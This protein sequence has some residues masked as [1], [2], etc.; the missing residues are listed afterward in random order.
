[1]LHRI[2]VPIL[3]LTTI[4]ACSEHPTPPPTAP[5]APADAPPPARE[6]L[7]ARLAVALADPVL[8]ADLATRFDASH[9]PEGKLQFQALARTGDRLLLA[10]LAAAG[11]GSMATLL[12]DLDAARGLELYLPVPAQRAAW[13]GSDAYLVGTLEHDGDRPV[14]F[15]AAG[16]RLVLDANQP[17]DIPVIAL[18]PQEFD[19]T[20][21]N[22]AHAMICWDLCSDGGGD[23]GGGMATPPSGLYLVSSHFDESHEGWLKGSPEFEFH[24]YGEVDGESEQL[25]CTGE[26]ARGAYHW[27]TNDLDWQGSAALL[28]K[29]DIDAYRARSPNGVIRIVAWEDDDTACVPVT[30][31]NS[32]IDMVNQLDAFY[33]KW[34]GARIKANVGK[35]LEAAV[36]AY[37]LAKS[38]RNFILTSDD[39]IGHAVETSVAGFAPGSAN[40]L[41]KGDGARTTGWFETVYRD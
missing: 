4:V 10:R 29:A 16:R 38:V 21:G 41:L 37:G 5:A 27:D 6:R 31:G 20:G 40:F 7:A 22:P 24:V 9:A 11:D 30:N 1:M 35:G 19:F 3:L 15:D 17:P 39:V 14:A 12:A 33:K 26:R 25:G 36:A 2:V 32:F 18:V 8:R 34:T 13:Q 28:T 23:D